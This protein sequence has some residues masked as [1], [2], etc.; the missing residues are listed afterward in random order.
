MRSHKGRID[1]GNHLPLHANP[2]FDAAQD[3]LAFQA[4]DAHS[5]TR[6]HKSFFASML[7]RNSLHTHLRLPQPKCTSCSSSCWISLGS[8]G[9]TC[10]ACPSHSGWHPFFHCVNCT[11]QL[12]VICKFAE[13]T[14]DPIFY[15]TDKDVEENLSQVR[16]LGGHHSSLA[17]TWTW[18][19]WPQCSVIIK[20]IFIYWIDHSPNPYISN[21]G[22]R[23]WCGI[24]PE[25][26]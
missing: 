17:F 19:C 16:F 2:S 4:S 5:Y 14:L 6:S 26:L 18:S 20:P 7:S 13:D 8:H 25:A 1:E 3:K 24:V 15:A 23:M 10:Q 21:L 12:G 22:I 9:M 11:T